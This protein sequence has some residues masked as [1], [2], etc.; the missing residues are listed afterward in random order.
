VFHTA[1]GYAVELGRLGLN[2]VEKIQRD[3]R[4]RR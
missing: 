4:L 1:P 3:T 2:A